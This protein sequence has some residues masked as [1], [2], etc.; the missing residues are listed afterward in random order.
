MYSRRKTAGIVLLCL[1]LC[2]GMTCTACRVSESGTQDREKT[3]AES[4]TAQIPSE[5]E[6]SSMSPEKNVKEEGDVSKDE[7]KEPGASAA[8]DSGLQKAGE[9]NVPDAGTKNSSAENS[10]AE[11]SSAENNRAEN[12]GNNSTTGISDYESGRALFDSLDPSVWE[13]YW[14]V[15][16]EELKT[17]LSEEDYVD[18]KRY[19]QDGQGGYAA[20]EYEC[21][22]ALAREAFDWQNEKRM[23]AGLPALMWDE[24]AYGL[25][26]ERVRQIAVNFSHDGCPPGYGENLASG[27]AGNAVQVI[28]RWYESEVHRTNMLSEDYTF[29]AI[30]CSDG[31]WVAL[32]RR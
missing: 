10:S 9:Q 7:S 4:L 31:L 13:L 2:A 11:N 5:E 30:A 6:E 8:G 32:F 17:N 27:S 29:G 23:E 21:D 28:D 24:E 1:S 14:Q 18:L 20:E 12:N 19:V 3:A 26:V 16:E 25:A 22:E 15:Y